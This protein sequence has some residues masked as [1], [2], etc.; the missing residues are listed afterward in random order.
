MISTLL[1]LF[2]F[3]QIV[4]TSLKEYKLSSKHRPYILSLISFLKSPKD[5]VTDLK[6]GVQKKLYFVKGITFY[7]K[8]DYFVKKCH[9]RKLP[10]VLVVDSFLV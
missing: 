5:F 6:K 8:V 9:F 4:N 3:I 1:N 7:Y 2:L 10:F